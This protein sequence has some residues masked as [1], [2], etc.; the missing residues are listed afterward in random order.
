MLLLLLLV[1]LYSFVEI[2]IGYFVGLFL[3]WVLIAGLGSSIMTLNYHIKAFCSNPNE[4]RKNIAI[5]FDDGPHEVTSLVLDVLKKYQVKA[6]FFCIGKNIEKYPEIL[7]RIAAEGHLIG[8]HSY[9][10]SSFFD[11]Y[12]TKRVLDEL[13]K[14]DVL[15]EKILGKK[16][17]FFRPPYGVTNPA[18]RNVIELTKHHVIGWNIR[19]LDTVIKDENKLFNRIKKRLAPGAIIL[20]HDTSLHTV[21]VLERLLL[22]LQDH[23][24]NVMP[25]EQLL[26]IKAYEN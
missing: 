16:P 26:N 15:L 6:A 24:Y 14:T 3:L 20:L 8:N 17:C 11:L 23:Q 12:G 21:K 22:F 4:K 9:S 5:T 2:A 18:I 19:S 13:E 1:V 10:H 25:L 7:Q